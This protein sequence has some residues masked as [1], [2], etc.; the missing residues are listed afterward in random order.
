MSSPLQYWVEQGMSKKEIWGQI[1]P[2]AISILL[3]KIIFTIIQELTICMFN[4]YEFKV[5]K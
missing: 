5:I 2:E 4:L 3:K 1:I